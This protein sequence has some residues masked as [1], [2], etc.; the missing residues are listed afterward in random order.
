MHTIINKTLAVAAL[1]LGSSVFSASSYADAVSLD[2]SSTIGA[3]GASI[4]GTDLS[5]PGLLTI[6]RPFYGTNT[7]DY[8]PIISGGI[9]TIGNLDLADMSTFNILGP[10]ERGSYVVSELVI[11]GQSAS[12]LD[13]YTRGVFTPGVVEGTQ[14]GGCA[15]GGNTC[16]A[17]D[18]SLRW[19]FSQSG[20]S[21][22]ASATLASPAVVL[23]DVPEPTSLSLLGIGLVGWLSSRRK[24]TMVV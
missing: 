3:F 23:N 21:V 11:M 8:S 22:S 19:S 1:A 2:G 10:V 24:S 6:D 4:T 15:T 12:F 7:G 18:T 9:F 17:S 5:A 13:I 20:D 16:A 14:A